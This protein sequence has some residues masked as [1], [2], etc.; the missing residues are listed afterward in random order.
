MVLLFVS[1]PIVQEVD[2]AA[3]RQAEPAPRVHHHLEQ[4]D[5]GIDAGATLTRGLH[6]RALA[7]AA[8]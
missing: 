3:A 4:T 2:G 8:F 5:P 7:E 1:L 6:P